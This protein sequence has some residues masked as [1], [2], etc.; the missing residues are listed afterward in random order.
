MRVPTLETPRLTVRPFVLGDLP[1]VYQLLDVDLAEADFG[2]EA[3][4]SVDE[5]RAWLEWQGGHP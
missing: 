3:A 4:Q 5:R 2:S 1:A